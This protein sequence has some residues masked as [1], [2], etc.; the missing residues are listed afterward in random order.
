MNEK[1]MKQY[2][3]ARKIV[4]ICYV[5]D[6]YKQMIKYMYEHLAIGPWTILSHQTGTTTDVELNG[7]VVDQE[8]RFVCAS[9][10]VG[11][12]EIEV[13]QPV[14]GPNPFSKFLETRGPGIH[15]IKEKIDD[16]VFQEMCQHFIK[17]GNE[18][19]YK[20]KYEEDMFVYLDTMLATGAM[21]ELGNC[22]VIENLPTLIGY[23]PEK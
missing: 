19:C 11:D 7:K 1:E 6:D 18:V 4:Q 3:E 20:G 22:P 14:C 9:A 10:W 23:Y 21:Y 13:I 12:M 5:T 17:K 2:N 16:S 15:H 8:F